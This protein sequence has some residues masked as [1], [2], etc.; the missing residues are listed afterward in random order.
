MNYRKYFTGDT[1]Q[2]QQQ[3]QIDP[4]DSDEGEEYDSNRGGAPIK[5]TRNG[6]RTQ[7]CPASQLRILVCGFTRKTIDRDV[8]LKR[9]K[10]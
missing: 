2:Q 6:I 10:T 8:K 4:I 9:S 5:F 1:K 7:D 3:Q